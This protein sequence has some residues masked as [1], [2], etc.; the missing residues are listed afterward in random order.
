MPN[1]IGDV[2]GDQETVVRR[3]EA[4]VNARDIIP[5]QAQLGPYPVVR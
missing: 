3:D 2:V 5:Y 1:D 4:A